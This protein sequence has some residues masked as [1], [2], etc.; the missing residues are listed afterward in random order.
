MP[1]IDEGLE[2][3]RRVLLVDDERG[4]LSAMGREL[5]DLP[6]ET[7]TFVDPMDALEA[8]RTQRF[9]VIVSDH[10]MPAISGLELL[11]AAMSAVPESRRVL[12]TGDMVADTVIDAF[13]DKVIHHYVSKP[14]SRGEFSNVVRQQ[15]EEFEARYCEKRSRMEL[16]EIVR[17]RTRQLYRALEAVRTIGS[18]LALDEEVSDVERKLAVVIVADVAGYSRLMEN[19]PRATLTT[20]TE[21]RDVFFT[22]VRTHKGRIV[23]APGDSILAEFSSTVDAVQCSLDVQAHLAARNEELPEERRMQFRIGVD[24]GDVL[25]RRGEIFGDAVNIA[26]RLETLTEPGGV[27]VTGAVYDLARGQMDVEWE[28]LGERRVKNIDRPLAVYGVSTIVQVS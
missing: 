15:L 4:A 11:R 22:L 3:A 18:E 20:L 6:C 13:N 28:L 14:W 7:C 12:L 27:S 21:Y 24:T 5:A 19:D 1:A 26:A 16:D 23:N 17:K 2:S 8:V 9:A 10:H 25:I